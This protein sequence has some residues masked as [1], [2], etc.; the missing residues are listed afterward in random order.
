MT[1]NS[2]KYLTTALPVFGGK[3]QSSP[4]SVRVV[5][6]DDVIFALGLTPVTDRHEGS[7]AAT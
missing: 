3:D 5:T 1:Q 6:D 4:Q 7:S 2:K